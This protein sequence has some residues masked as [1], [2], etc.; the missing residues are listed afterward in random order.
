[1][2]KQ[3]GNYSFVSLSQ[4]QY[5]EILFRTPQSHCRTLL[6]QWGFAAMYSNNDDM[7]VYIPESV[8]PDLTKMEG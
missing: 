3:I 2:K 6:K 4:H 1:M 8:L 7:A 5:R